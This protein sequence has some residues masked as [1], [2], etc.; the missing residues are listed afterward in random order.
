LKEIG[1]SDQQITQID[2]DASSQ[3]VKQAIAA[4]RT[5]VEQKIKTVK[6]PTII[7]GGHRYER[8]IDA[9]QLK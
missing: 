1:Y 6:I 3:T 8:V 7:F 5:T 4:Q 2:V 9:K